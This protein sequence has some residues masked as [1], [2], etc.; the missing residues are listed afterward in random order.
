MNIVYEEK[1]KIF[2]L[3]NEKISYVMKLEKDC[4]LSHCYF[5][6]RLRR[7]SGSAGMYY[8]DRGFCANP[9]EIRCRENIR[10]LVRETF[11]VRQWS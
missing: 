5:G 7:W 11:E 3:Y 1:S 6:K 8:Y 10:I 9:D 4:Y 2:H